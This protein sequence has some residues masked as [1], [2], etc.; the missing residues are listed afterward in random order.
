MVAVFGI[1]SGTLDGAQWL[2]QNVHVRTGSTKI[3]ARYLRVKLLIPHRDIL[4]GRVSADIRGAEG[5]IERVVFP[6]YQD[7]WAR[8]DVPELPEEFIAGYVKEAEV[9]LCDCLPEYQSCDDDWEAEELDIY[10]SVSSIGFI[11]N[12]RLFIKD[13]QPGTTIRGVIALSD[14]G[15]VK[16]RRRTRNVD[17][18]PPEDGTDLIDVSVARDDAAGVDKT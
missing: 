17:A 12:V 10:P 15:S 11:V 6:Q 5:A 13:L 8:R 9:D 4:Y 2:G 1:F 14:D 16:L 7:L 18:S 3:E